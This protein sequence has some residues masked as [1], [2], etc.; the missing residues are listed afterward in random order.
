MRP[1]LAPALAAASLALACSSPHYYDTDAPKKD[2]ARELPPGAKG[3]RLLDPSK[4]PDFSP[5]YLNRQGMIEALD[6]SADYMRRPSSDAF[7]PYFPEIDHGR[8]EATVRAFR[9]DLT[10][11]T[12]GADLDRRIRDRYDVYESVG[13]NGEGEMLITAYHEP[14]YTASLTPTP[15][16]RYPLYRRPPELETDESGEKAFLKRADGSLSAAP[17]RKE[18]VAGLKGRGLELV[19]LADPFEAYVVQVQGSARFRLADGKELR[20]SYAGDNGQEYKP[21]WEALVEQGK[22]KKS[23][24]SLKRLQQ[25]FAQHPDEVEAAV[26]R[27]PRFVFFQERTGPAVGCLNVP[28]TPWH[29]IA[30]DRNRKEDVF[31][32][33][34]VA[35][36][37][38]QLARTPG[39]AAS[40][41]SSFVCDQD[42]GGAIRSAGRADLFLGTGSDAEALAGRTQAEGRLYYVFLKVDKVAPVLAELRAERDAAKPAAARKSDPAA[43]KKATPA[44]PS[45]TKKPKGKKPGVDPKKT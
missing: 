37:S 8:A 36:L 26:D 39:G 42:R 33:A 24:L 15:R 21:V 45:P 11:A 28:V 23:E 44:A 40:A 4:Y 29:T 22:L 7:F 38:T 3:L 10:E 43:A 32:R 41:W 27:N 31:P 35:F 19:Y 30:T 18:L 34:G 1:H 14:T 6:A 9:H 2:Y 5:G 16:F 17:P 12:N 25:Y 20:V 13:W